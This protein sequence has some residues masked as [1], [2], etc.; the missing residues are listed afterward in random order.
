M[1]GSEDMC[2]GQTVNADPKL[3][4]SKNIMHVIMVTIVALIKMYL[5]VLIDFDQQ[6]HIL[7]SESSSLLATF[8]IAKSKKTLNRQHTFKLA[9]WARLFKTN[10]IVS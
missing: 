2:L 8:R 5:K 7:R 4:L 6:I 1:Y 10:D 9:T 3:L